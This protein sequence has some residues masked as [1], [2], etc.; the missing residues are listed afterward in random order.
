MAIYRP[1]QELKLRS[2]E[3]QT[4]N[5]KLGD[6]LID[7]ILK[8]IYDLHPRARNLG[9]FL[10]RGGMR[11]EYELSEV[12]AQL[13]ANTIEDYELNQ[14]SDAQ[15]KV[16]TARATT[17]DEL[18]LSS[19]PDE[20]AKTLIQDFAL[21]AKKQAKGD[22]QQDKFVQ[23]YYLTEVSGKTDVYFNR[24]EL[25]IS[26]SADPEAVQILNLLSNAR[27]SAK[28]YGSS[29]EMY[30]DLHLGNSNVFRA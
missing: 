20:I 13:M 14:Q 5:V 9:L 1:L 23:K 4:K 15:F 3:V 27:I 6:G 17:V 18:N 10:G 21:K 26:A 19:I 2:R 25:Q 24:G 16:G 12:F 28:N 29:E 7:S 22:L 30:A 11:F 8:G